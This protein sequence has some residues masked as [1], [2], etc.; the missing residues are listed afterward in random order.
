MFVF[1]SLSMILSRSS[2]VAANGITSFF[3]MAE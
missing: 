2:H 3:I 1:L